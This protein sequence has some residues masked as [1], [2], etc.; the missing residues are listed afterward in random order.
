M[1]HPLRGCVAAWLGWLLLAAPLAADDFQ[2]EAGYQSL[3]TGKDLSGWRYD[4]ERGS[5]EGKKATPDRRI[6]VKDGVLT[7]HAGKGIH[8]LITAREFNTDFHLK[9]EFRAGLRADS[10]V[11]IRGYQ[12]QLRDFERRHER[13]DLKRFRNDGWNEL[14][15]TVKNQRLLCTLNGEQLEKRKLRDLIEARKMHERG[16]IGLQ[17]EDGQFE[18]RRLRI[19]ELK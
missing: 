13:P 14:E 8:E 3:F 19:K 17:A 18:Y 6:T 7:I 10:G 12:I 5:L 15:I 1:S 9:L 2:N 4:H 11:Y 16:P